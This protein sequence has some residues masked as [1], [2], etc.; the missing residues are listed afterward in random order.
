M[1]ALSSLVCSLVVEKA[2]L[3]ERNSVANSAHEFIWSSL[4]KSE[5]YEVPTLL[6]H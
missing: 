6:Q 2:V 4:D 1:K 3:V 5:Q